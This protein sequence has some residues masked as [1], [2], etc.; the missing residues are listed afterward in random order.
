MSRKPQQKNVFHKPITDQQYEKLTNEFIVRL[1]ELS[2]PQCLDAEFVAAI[3]AN[4]IHS[5]D[6]KG[7]FITKDKIFDIVVDLIAKRLSFQISEGIRL[8]KESEQKK[9]GETPTDELPSPT[10]EGNAEH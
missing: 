5:A 2:A 10:T 1:N 7:G 4:A 3:L 6:A 8:K 9:A